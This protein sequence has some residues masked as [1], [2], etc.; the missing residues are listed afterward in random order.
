MGLRFFARLADSF[1]GWALL[2]SL[3]LAM[4]GIAFYYQHVLGELPCVLCIHVRLL[5]LGLGLVALVELFLHRVRGARLLG[6][7]AVLGLGAALGWRAWQLLATE[8]GWTV[9]ECSM[10]LGLPPWLALD[11][12]WPGFFRPEVPCG[13]TPV[14]P[15]GFTMAEVLPAIA[16]VLLFVAAAAL[17]GEFAE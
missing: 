4:E 12:W 2:L 10:D 9:G 11:R 17:L 5:V 7:L 15:G 6:E 3:A 8:R 14:L 1:L 13:Y 16:A